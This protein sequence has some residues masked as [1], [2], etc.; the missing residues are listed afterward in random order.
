MIFDLARSSIALLFLLY[1]SWSDYKTRE[2]SNK[3]WLIFGPVAFALTT[4]EL[5]LYGT[6][7]L[8]PYAICFGLTSC[9]AILLF[10]TGGFG[11]AD[12]KAL[13]CLALALP[14]YPERILTPITNQ[15][16]LISEK[17]F[18]ITVFT[19]SVLFA[20][21]TA[22]ALLLY[23]L[24]RRLRT[25]EDLFQGDL[26]SESIGKKIV[27]M[28]TAYKV[29]VEELEKKWHVYPLEDVQKNDEDKPKRKLIL[30]PKDEGRKEI[31]ERID[32]AVKNGTIQNSIWATPGLPMLIF[33]LA[34]LIT[35]LFFGDIVWIC[36]RLLLG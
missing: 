28:L 29:P 8:I 16:S 4:I 3:V 7:D 20:A 34:G 30:L 15:V 5:F 32:Q 10:Y 36:I 35:A 2:V 6:S 26:K 22:V 18:P 13:M 19:N 14:F 21:F 24:F 9:F 25:H 17:F 31:V 23:N 33:I 11:G 1:A 12:A 27:V